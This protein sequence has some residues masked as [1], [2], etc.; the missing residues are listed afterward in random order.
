MS[1]PPLWTAEMH[2]NHRFYIYKRLSI[3][4]AK[5]GVSQSISLICKAELIQHVLHFAGKIQEINAR[6]I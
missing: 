3:A 6:L 1:H 4:S 2:R 5:A